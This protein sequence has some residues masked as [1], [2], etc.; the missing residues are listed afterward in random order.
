MGDISAHFDKREFTCKCGK[1]YKADIDNGL[2]E[3]LEQLHDLM[4][5]H[6]IIITSGYRCPTWSKSVGGYFNDAH[7]KGIA[8]DIVVYKSFNS[9]YTSYDVAEAAE[10]VG[11]TGIG[12]IDN[13][14]VHVDIRNNQNYVNSH[15]FGNEMTGDDNIKTFQRGTKFV[16]R[17]T[18]T[19]TPE[20][21]KEHTIEII[22]DGKSIYKGVIK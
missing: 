19:E 2:I 14:A 12:I 11:F 20:P 22:I 9:P 4:N 3:K 10:R 18:K 21:E 17:E 8:A 6:S 1:C 5:A 13:I 15:W 16:S 7:T